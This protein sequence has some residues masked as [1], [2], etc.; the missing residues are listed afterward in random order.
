MITKWSDK[1]RNKLSRKKLL[2]DIAQVKV[3]RKFVSFHDSK[4]VGILIDATNEQ[5]HVLINQYIK[6]IQNLHKQV[7]VLAFFNTKKDQQ[8]NPIIQAGYQYF[9]RKDLSW[10]NLPEHAA[11]KS[12]A[13]EEFDIL[14]NV[15]PNKTLPLNYISGIS[16]ARCRVG[17]YDE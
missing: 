11:A 8:P 1:L 3:Q 5:L 4:R 13:N 15:N 6:S 12:F 7:N 17:M 10:M 14:I 2:K 16:K 9:T